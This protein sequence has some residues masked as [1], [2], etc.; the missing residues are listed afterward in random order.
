MG[1]EKKFTNEQALEGMLQ[2]ACSTLLGLLDKIPDDKLQYADVSQ[3]SV[4]LLLASQFIPRLNSAEQGVFS[5]MERIT[6]RS[7]SDTERMSICEEAMKAFETDLET[8]VNTPSTS[9]PRGYQH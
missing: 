1:E 6:G 9:S 5:F 3:V 4:L 7:L 2:I 8:L